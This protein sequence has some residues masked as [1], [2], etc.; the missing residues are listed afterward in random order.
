MSFLSCRQGRILCS[1]ILRMIDIIDRKICLNGGQEGQRKLKA[2]SVAVIGA[3][4]V[5]STLLMALV[6]G[7]IGR[8]GIIEFDKVELSNLNRQVLYRTSD[9][10]LPK[11]MA[12]H[13]T[14]TNLNPDI[15]IELIEE[16]VSRSNI[17]RLLQ[18]YDFIVE[19]GESPDGRNAVNEYCLR[20]NK[21]MVHA[22]AQFSYGYVFSMLPSRNSACFACLFPRDHSRVEHTGPV[23][24]NVLSTSVAG[25][26][27][28]AEVFKW[29]LGYEEKMYFN[30]RLTF[31]SL[32][33]S[34]VFSVDEVAKKRECEYCSVYT[35]E[36]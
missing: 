22:S 27:G 16:K 9:V 4:G 10:G 34:G 23:P 3:G 29:F 1:L 18:S 25:T 2:A 14:L 32:L 15:T 17:D 5:K 31:S 26:L 28:A 11:G 20:R 12:A 19:G 8:I 6:A 24:V 36:R 33:L 21:P 7:G 30:K 35:E 13:K